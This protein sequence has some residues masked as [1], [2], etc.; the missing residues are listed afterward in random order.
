MG[1]LAAGSL[2]R[3]ITLHRFG[4]IEDEFGDRVEGFTPIATVYASVRSSPG[5]ERVAN[6]QTG[7]TSAKIIRI[8]YSSTVAD[9][10]PKDRVEYP[11]GS[12]KMLDITS[13]DEIGYKDGIEIV[14]IG[15]AD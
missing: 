4:V 2:D 15:V 10:N 14:A 3:R 1:G 12:G 6:A 13:A 9:L 11:I 8:R 7:A 5:A